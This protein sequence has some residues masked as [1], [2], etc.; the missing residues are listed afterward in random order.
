[1]RE[2]C[3][4][5]AGRGLALGANVAHMVRSRLNDACAVTAAIARKGMRVSIRNEWVERG[6]LV[7]DGDTFKVRCRSTFSGT[8]LYDFAEGLERAVSDGLLEGAAHVEVA[9]ATVGELWAAGSILEAVASVPNPRLRTLGLGALLGAPGLAD[10]EGSWPRVKRSFPALE[11]GPADCWRWATSPRLRVVHVGPHFA[12][13][14]P[15]QLFLLEADGGGPWLALRDPPQGATAFDALALQVS[16]NSSNVAEVNASPLEA[17]DQVRVNGI[18]VEVDRLSVHR[19]G[20]LLH[21]GTIQWFPVN[22]D[23]IEVV[24]LSVRYEEDVG[25]APFA[26]RETHALFMG[27]ASSNVTVTV[28]EPP[29]KEDDDDDDD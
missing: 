14:S 21:K 13:V 20:E 22:G 1:M 27:G 15:N 18:E 11:H 3:G 25:H 16:V 29:P 9:V 2:W 5:E 17:D 23:L 8:R 26:S 28:G 4:D 24:G 12:R 10:I 6:A 7:I 19:N